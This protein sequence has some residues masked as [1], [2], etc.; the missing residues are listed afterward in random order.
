MVI[1]QWVFQ[2]L[3]C[4]TLVQKVQMQHWCVTR[5][6][7]PYTLMIPCGASG[8]SHPTKT[9][10]AQSTA[11]GMLP[12][13]TPNCHQGCILEPHGRTSGSNY[14]TWL[15]LIRVATAVQ[16]SRSKAYIMKL[17]REPTATCSSILFQVRILNVWCLWYYISNYEVLI[18]TM[19]SRSFK[20]FNKKEITF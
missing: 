14:R 9:S 7:V 8:F 15:M 6:V 3:T 12:L 10:T 18:T 11:R 17:C 4:T 13:N 5:E 16:P 20:A 19:S 1:Q 2:P